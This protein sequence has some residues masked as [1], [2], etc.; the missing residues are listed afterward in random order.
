MV[1]GASTRSGPEVTSSRSERSLPG[2]A[3][4]QVSSGAGLAS[5]AQLSLTESSLSS[6]GPAFEVEMVRVSAAGGS[7][8]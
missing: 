4:S 2:R 3:R 8:T 7:E 5:A 6:S 1:T